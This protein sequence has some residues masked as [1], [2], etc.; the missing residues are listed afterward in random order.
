MNSIILYT[1]CSFTDLA[2]R[3]VSQNFSTLQCHVK[4]V[5]NLSEFLHSLK[6]IKSSENAI[7]VIDLI[8]QSAFWRVNYL[9]ALWN[10]RRISNNNDIRNVPFLLL[11]DRTQTLPSFLHHIPLIYDLEK[12]E[13]HL[14]NT[15]NC[16]KHYMLTPIKKINKKKRFL[17]YT[18]TEG[19]NLTDTAFTL[20]VSVKSIRNRQEALMRQIGLKNRYEMALLAGKLLL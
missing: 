14:L 19:F 7:I 6:S 3:S 1:Q 2:F 20:N 18:I 4:T 13:I 16:K 8:K 11:G 10:F 15:L 17:M 9:N 5:S 12:I